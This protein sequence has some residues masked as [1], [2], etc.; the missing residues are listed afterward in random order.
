MFYIWALGKDQN[1]VEARVLCNTRFPVS[2]SLVTPLTLAR[3]NHHPLR[4]F[5]CLSCLS[6]SP[7]PTTDSKWH[8]LTLP[9]APHRTRWLQG[10][11]QPSMVISPT[12]T[13]LAEVLKEYK[14]SMMRSN[15]RT[16]FELETSNCSDV[17]RRQDLST[18]IERW[19]L[20]DVGFDYNIVAVFGSQS[21]GKSM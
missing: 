12:V 3:S 13:L 18:Q 11:S 1:Y 5:T 4:V 21:T 15:S 19:G 16:R 10:R 7:T 2:G 6:Y 17:L 8:S 9:D 20:R 14:L